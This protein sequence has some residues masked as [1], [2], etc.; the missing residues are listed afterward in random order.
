MTPTTR[1][2]LLALW[3]RCPETIPSDGKSPTLMWHTGFGEFQVPLSHGGEW[4]LVEDAI[5]EQLAEA[6]LFRWL[7]GKDC[8]PSLAHVLGEGDD[9]YASVGIKLRLAPSR[10]DSS[11]FT[12]ETPLGS[13]IAATLFILDS[14]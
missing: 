5:A 6:A 11:C 7:A 14:H 10:W 3:K 12:R 9:T 13:L 8:E 4:G 2:N 1:D